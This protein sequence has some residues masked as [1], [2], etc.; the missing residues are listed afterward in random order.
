MLIRLRYLWAHHRLLLLGFV[1][2]LGVT[3]FFGIRTLSFTLYWMDPAH[4]DQTLAGWMTPGYVALSYDIPP[5][6]LA[7]ALFDIPGGA[8]T[9]MTMAKIAETHGITLDAL[10]ARV[11][12][13]VGIFR[14]GQP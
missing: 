14:E 10:Q 7:L 8:P 3:L 12:L 4:Q 2:V 5:P 1:A 11:R 6:V 9:P 13:A